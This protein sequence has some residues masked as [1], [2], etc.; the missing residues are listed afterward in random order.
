MKIRDFLFV[1]GEIQLIDT[2]KIELI[3]IFNPLKQNYLRHS[4]HDIDSL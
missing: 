4:E 3:L 2:L 1:G